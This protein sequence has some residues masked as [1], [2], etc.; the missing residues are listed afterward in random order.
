MAADSVSKILVIIDWQ[1]FFKACSA[2][3]PAIK[4]TPEAIVQRAIQEIKAMIVKRG[5]SFDVRLFV[6]NYFNNTHIWRLIN[7]LQ[8]KYGLT[9]EICPVLREE[10]DRGERDPFER[11]VI[12]KDMVDISVV[13]WMF[14]YVTK[15]VGFDMIVF[16]SGDSHFL[17]PTNFARDQG[18]VVKFWT[19]DRDGTTSKLIVENEGV[20]EIS[21]LGETVEFQ[22]S[23]YIPILSKITS[24]SILDEDELRK[25]RDLKR[26]VD[27]LPSWESEV[28]L[29]AKLRATAEKINE[30]LAISIDDAL[31]ILRILIMYKGLRIYPEISL[32]LSLSISPL[33]MWLSALG[34][35][36]KNL[37]VS[38]GK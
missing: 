29:E 13:S 27:F 25:M 6:P 8:V 34:E 24:G 16:I 31:D 37:E 10:P 21:I 9:V 26:V 2:K 30:A 18:K 5:S 1:N 28:T 32:G 17:G 19:I 15:A 22:A 38:G 14:R 12:Y 3:S 11:G 7:S 35:T 4:S 33:V 20:E 23:P 36:F